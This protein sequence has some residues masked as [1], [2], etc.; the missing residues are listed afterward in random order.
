[1]F[2]CGWGEVCRPFGIRFGTGGEVAGV[3]IREMEKIRA[4]AVR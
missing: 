4:D 3:Y 1:M 2:V